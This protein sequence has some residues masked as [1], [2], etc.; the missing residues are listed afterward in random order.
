MAALPVVGALVYGA[1]AKA[2]VATTSDVT[3]A[4]SGVLTNLVL[5]IIN[6][7]VSFF[8]NNWPIIAITSVCIGL[9]FFF[10]HMARRAGRGR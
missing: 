9:V 2:D 10:Y 3:T 8:T 1:A 5:A 4:F 6:V 7:V